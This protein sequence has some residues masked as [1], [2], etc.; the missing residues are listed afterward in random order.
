MGKVTEQC[1]LKPLF[2]RVVIRRDDPVKKIGN[3]LLPDNAQ[4]KPK[5]GTVIAVGPGRA[6]QEAPADLKPGA[7][8]LLSEYAGHTYDDEGEELVIVNFDDVLAVLGD[9][10]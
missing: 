10:R 5:R 4:K 3:I 6:D 8:I 7:K 1:S 2:D 9:K